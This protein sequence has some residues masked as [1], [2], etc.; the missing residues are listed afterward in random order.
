VRPLRNDG[1]FKGRYL[2][3]KDYKAARRIRDYKILKKVTRE[4]PFLLNNDI[5]R[6]DMRI[7]NK[8]KYKTIP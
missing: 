5:T 4:Q 7:N 8:V 6:L 2:H 3:K 1:T